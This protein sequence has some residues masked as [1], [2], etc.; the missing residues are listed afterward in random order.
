M[1]DL[2]KQHTKRNTPDTKEYLQYFLVHLG[3]YHK[4]E[5][6]GWYF[7]QFRRLESPRSGCQQGQALYGEGPCL[8]GRLLPCCCVPTWRKQVRGI[9]GAPFI[10]V[11]TPFMR[12]KLHDNSRSY[13]I[14]LFTCLFNSFSWLLHHHWNQYIFQSAWRERVETVPL[15]M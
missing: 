1:H 5:K 3:S 15:L 11:L 6:T 10:K 7:S 2:K 8:S 9:S 4:I 14:Y 13:F 12:M